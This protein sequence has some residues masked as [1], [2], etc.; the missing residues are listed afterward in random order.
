MGLDQ[1]DYNKWKEEHPNIKNPCIRIYLEDKIK[2]QV[3]QETA[4]YRWDKTQEKR[5]PLV[6]IPI[7]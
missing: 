2:N 5:L 4:S 1:N 3:A 6:D 7:Y